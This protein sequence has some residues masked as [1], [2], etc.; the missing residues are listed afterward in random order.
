MT[1]RYAPAGAPPEVNL[2]R[3]T[4]ADCPAS[5]LAVALGRPLLSRPPRQLRPE[6]PSPDPLR[7]RPAR[8]LALDARTRCRVV[9]EL[10]TDL[11]ALDVAD[12]RDAPAPPR[13][14]AGIPVHPR[15]LVVHVVTQ[16]HIE[17]VGLEIDDG[18]APVL[19]RSPEHGVVLDTRT[20]SGSVP[21]SATPPRSNPMTRL[22]GAWQCEKLR[23]VAAGTVVRIMAT[24]DPRVAGTPVGGTAT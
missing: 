18:C 7:P 6:A 15:A 22:Q 20:S 1:P 11:G 19:H 14:A 23:S 10:A 4:A 8:G 21:F 9:A 16:P 5:A 2:R 17:V 24:V 12:V 13:R 3:C